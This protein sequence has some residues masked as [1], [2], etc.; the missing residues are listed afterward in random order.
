MLGFFDFSI[1]A[2]C[3][4]RRETWFMI[5][6]RLSVCFFVLLNAVIFFFR[7]C[8]ATLFDFAVFAL[9]TSGEMSLK[10][11]H[12][13]DLGLHPWRVT[14]KRLSELTTNKEVLSPS[15]V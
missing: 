3:G 6:P 2:L 7:L 13:P 14:H 5:E 4:F 9:I 11:S 15:I 8:L 1:G 10:E 12:Q